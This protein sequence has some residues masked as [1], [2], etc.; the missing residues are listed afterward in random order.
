MDYI[1]ILLQLIL[2]FYIFYNTQAIGNIAFGVVGGIVLHLIIYLMNHLSCSKRTKTFLY[3]IHIIILVLAAIFISNSFWILVIAVNTELIYKYKYKIILLNLL[4]VLIYLWVIDSLIFKEQGVLFVL[5]ILFLSLVSKYEEKI[6]SIKKANEELRDKLYQANLKVETIQKEV[7]QIEELTKI[8]E[9]NMLVQ[10]LHDKIGHTLAANIMQ[11]EA[12]KIIL[13]S[14]SAEATKMLTSTIENLRDGMDDIRHTLKDIKP[15]QSEVGINQIRN[16]LE[17]L[18]STHK[19]E[20][21]LS[22]EGDIGAISLN[23]WHVTLQNLKETITNLIK[24]SKADRLSVRIEVFHKIIKIQFKDNGAP[25]E[26]YESG[27]GLMGIEERTQSINGRLVINTNNGFE[28]LMI[29]KREG[30]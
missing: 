19:I 27:L 8:Q 3:I 20:T 24:H 18:Q 14:N 15:E 4:G 30:I 25:I 9:R 28:T 2:S 23:V 21:E 26:H 1:S 13:Q 29:L 22:F 7:S 6:K 16:I 5:V 10:K 11:L 12:I 17:D